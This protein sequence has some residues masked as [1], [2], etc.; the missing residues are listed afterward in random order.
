MPALFNSFFGDHQQ[1]RAL[2]HITFTLFY[3]CSFCVYCQTSNVRHTLVGNNI[4]VH[5]D[6][7]GVSPVRAAST[8]SSILTQHLASMDWA[9]TTARQDE[10]YLTLWIWYTLY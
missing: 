7:V 4:V 8:A 5:S 2:Q 3:F 10:E 6:V 9:K 1:K